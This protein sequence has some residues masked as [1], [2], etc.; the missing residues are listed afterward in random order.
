MSQNKFVLIILIAAIFCTF[1]IFEIKRKSEVRVLN[2]LSA[3]IIQVDLNSNKIA[4]KGETICIEGVQAFTSD[5][6]RNQEELAK[7]LQISNEDALKLGYLSDN[8]AQNILVGKKIKLKFSKRENQDCRF[9]EIT[10][11]NEAYRDK[12]LNSG[13][14]FYKNRPVDIS[15][16]NKQ[17]EKAKKL[18]LVILNHKS[19]KY[20]TLNC[21][22]GKIAHDA[23]IL[24]AKEIPQDAMPCKFCH[25]T[26]PKKSIEQKQIHQNINLYPLAISNGTLK[27]YLTDL[28]TT[29]KP[30]NKCS[31]LACKEILNQINNSKNSID[32]ALYGWDN[33]AEISKALDR[34]KN[35]GVKIRLVYDTSETQ[36]YKEMPSIISLADETSTDTPKILMHNKFIIF[37]NSKVITGSMNFARTGFSGFNSDC[38]IFINSSEAAKIYEEEFNQMFSGKFHNNKQQVLHKTVLIGKTSLT[39]LFSPKDKII[40]NNIIP[41]INNSKKYIYI[42]AFL[43]THDE[44]ASALISAKKRG[45]D[46][47]LIIDAT[48]T[49]ASRSKVKMLRAF[50]IPV[51]I[52]NYAGKLH[53]KSIIIDD[54]YIIAGSMNFSKSGENK[55]DENVLIIEDERLAKYYRGFFEY[56]WKK[57]PDKYLK[58]GVRAEGKYSIGSCSDGIDN[59]FDGK[60]DKEDKGCR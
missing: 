37:D 35:R 22:Y 48:N 18:K 44:L 49:Y 14:V 47:K 13:L 54:K 59:N 1:T 9:A 53:S 4:D 26:T 57:I 15:N 46:V 16:Y 3:D 38:V 7:T 41:L 55:N 52:E 20:H 6:S 23:I 50:G 2:V 19:N 31:S 25:I 34:A 39:P 51:K 24:P 40:I 27:L 28:T 33:I 45:I 29:L 32:I 10:V 30:E 36:Y 43:I 58:Q 5:L 17:L 60:I 8:F 42:P 56:L 21:K 12:L 11:N